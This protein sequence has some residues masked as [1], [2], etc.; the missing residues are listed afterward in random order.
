MK[1][2][3]LHAIANTLCLAT[4]MTKHMNFMKGSLKG[5]S[6]YIHMKASSP[7]SGYS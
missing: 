7:M 2:F 1:Y 5:T 6:W 4:H 3:F